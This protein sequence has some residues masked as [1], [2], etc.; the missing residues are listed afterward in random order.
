M[1]YGHFSQTEVNRIAL[2]LGENGILF[3]IY[4]DPEEFENV[5]K[6]VK[7]QSP[8]N[9][10]L[11]ATLNA[12]ILII[13]IEDGEWEKVGETLKA[14]LAKE[15]IFPPGSIPEEL[16]EIELTSKSFSESHRQLQNRNKIKVIGVSQ[17]IQLLILALILGIYLIFR[18]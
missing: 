10:L 3:D 11:G 16:E 9:Y 14:K 7:E 18:F 15:R 8:L 1:R 6:E 17:L 13:E 2:L 4:P 12:D 5:Q